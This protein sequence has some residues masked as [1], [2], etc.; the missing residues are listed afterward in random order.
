MAMLQRQHFYQD[1]IFAR[2]T[3]LLT[4]FSSAHLAS[5]LMTDTC[6]RCLH[7]SRTVRRHKISQARPASPKQTFSVLDLLCTERLLA[8]GETMATTCQQINKRFQASSFLKRL[9]WAVSNNSICSVKVSACTPLEARPLCTQPCKGRLLHQLSAL[10]KH[11]AP[12]AETTIISARAS[13]APL[14]PAT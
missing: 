2:C 4:M 9:T 5:G 13:M 11:A 1:W 12:S 3:F 14:H 6:C 8:P 7:R 10:G